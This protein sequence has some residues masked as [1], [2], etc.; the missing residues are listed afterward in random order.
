L[1]NL[2]NKESIHCGAG[3]TTFRFMALRASREPGEWIL[4]GTDR[5]LSRPQDELLKVL[6]QLGVEAQLDSAGLKIK[7]QGW[8]I[9]GDGVHVHSSQSSQYASALL[10]SS[11]DLPF[12]MNISLS[13]QQVSEPYWRMS[14]ALCR[15]CGMQ[16]QQ[17]ERDY[18]IPPYQ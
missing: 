11:W 9:Q 5:L 3:G 8:R 12:A 16:I 17:S 10:L 18:Y 4:T 6:R 7:T 15:Q 13:R 14:L 2:R 1:Q